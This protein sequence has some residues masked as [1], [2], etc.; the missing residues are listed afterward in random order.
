MTTIWLA[1]PLKH[2]SISHLILTP[3]NDIIRPTGVGAL[4][5]CYFQYSIVNAYTSEKSLPEG[6]FNIKTL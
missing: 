6:N 2:N 1:G 4:Q 5:Y 3:Q